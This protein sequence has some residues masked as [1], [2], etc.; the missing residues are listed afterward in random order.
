MLGFTARL[1]VRVVTQISTRTLGYLRF[2]CDGENCD[3]D[4]GRAAT[5]VVVAP[6]GR[7]KSDE[8]AVESVGWQ[9]VR[10]EG[11]AWRHLCR[12]CQVLG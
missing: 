4:N 11:A 1:T 8:R 3:I 9:A 7:W 5:V 10:K 12:D 2:R 6:S